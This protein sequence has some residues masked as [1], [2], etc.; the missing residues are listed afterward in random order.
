MSKYDVIV[1][2]LTLKVAALVGRD[3]LFATV[4]AISRWQLPLAAALTP[5]MQASTW[6]TFPGGMEGW[7]DLGGWLYTEMVY[8]STDPSK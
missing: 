3:Y 4:T 5:A 8:M 1:S 7:V 6:F 2:Y